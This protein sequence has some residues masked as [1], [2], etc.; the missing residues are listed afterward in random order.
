MRRLVFFVS[1]VLLLTM[2]APLALAQDA[3]ELV[4]WAEGTVANCFDE[5]ADAPFNCMFGDRMVNGFMEQHPNITIKVENHGWDE[6][7]RQNIVSA[8]LA[9][10]APDIAVGESFVPSLAASGAYAEVNISEE[11]M[12]NIVPGT[13]APAM[14]DGKLYGVAGFTA[15]FA[16]EVNADVVR[17]AG[18]D[19]DTL[20]LST[21]DKVTTVAQQ[22]ND[23]GQGEYYGFSLLAPTAWPVAA[24]FRVAPYLY[25][26]EGAFCN[27]DCTAPTFNTPQVIP[28]Y[29]WFRE[30]YA[31]TPPGLAFN[32]DEGFVFSQLFSGFTAMQ[33]AGTWHPKWALDSGCTDC[34][35]FPLPTRVEGGK[36]ANVVVSNVIYSVMETSEH[37]E[38]AMMFLEWI[39]NDEVQRHTSWSAGRLPT[40]Y[41]GLKI[42][43]EIGAGDVGQ[44]PDTWDAATQGDPIAFIQPY[45]GYADELMNGD[46]GTLPLWE[47]RA[48][49]LNQVWNDMF[50]E[51]LTTDRPI[52]EITDEFQVKAEEI[53]AQ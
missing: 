46:V 29:E 2:L 39:L 49:E 34:R 11:A 16:L 48:P 7:L 45:L 51:I 20:D 19:P 52:Q 12:Q 26:E 9:G 21:W 30:L 36:R 53:A 6:E 17:K 32:G 25:Q 27:E 31:L 37:K 43:E 44:V 18:L 28:V 41:S 3:V 8:Q 5:T 40:T 24:Q 4:L 42:L 35:Y 15:V 1:C 22:I 14:H 50:A 23:A 38:E 10:T 47:T 33:T 13:V